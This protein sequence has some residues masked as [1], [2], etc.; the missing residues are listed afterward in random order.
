M[1]TQR[2]PERLT[3]LAAAEGR[4]ALY[5]DIH[6]HCNISY[7]RGPLDAALARAR[8]QLDF[9]SV[10]GHAYWPDMPV[11]DPRVADIVDFHVKG[12]AR[13]ERLWL[14]HFDTL[15][16]FD[17]PGTFTVFPGYEMHSSAHGDHTIVLKSLDRHDM[18]RGDSPAELLAALRATYGAD[19]FAFPHH[20]AY[21]T[22]ARGINWD[23]FEPDLSPIVELISM[24]GSSESSLGQRPFLHSMGPG[25]GRNTV[26]AGWSMGHVFGLIGNTDHHSG[27][28]GSYGHGRGVVYATGS[29]RDAIWDAIHARHTGALTGDNIHLFS[30][31]NGTL[32]GD[33]L[34]PCASARLE[35]EAVGGSFIDRID[36]VKNGRLIDRVTPAITPAPVD[37]GSGGLETLLV[38]E[39]GW[40]RRGAAHDWTGRL[41]VENGEVLAVEPRLRGPEV[42][43]PQEGGETA[44]RADRVTRDGN[45]I[46]FDIRATGNPNNF[47]TSTQSIAAR[48]RLEA[49]A[50]VRLDL[51]E[52]RFAFDAD[53]LRRGAVSANLGAIDSPAFRIHPLPG[54]DDW[55]WAGSRDIGPL[56]AGDWVALRLHQA[57]GQSAW[58]TAHFC[59]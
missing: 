17:S 12:F 35:I 33:I 51:P 10:T 59:R 18:P 47:T 34:S 11:D 27:Y 25:H 45:A 58:S 56:S 36:V 15:K 22:G 46:G 44:P 20:I 37:T 13:L 28:P 54:P 52:G 30:R 50:S 23:T 55:Q 14:G 39:F 21:R 8:A 42:V 9:V 26:D 6:N 38:V 57:N 53:T 32:P 4:I 3:P 16:A 40:G 31:L 7:G 19:A 1:P 41:S 2:L 49:D 5:G 29:G 43:S 48:V 24:H